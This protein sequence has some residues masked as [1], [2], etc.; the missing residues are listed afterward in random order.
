[1]RSRRTGRAAAA[2]AALL[3]TL[4]GGASLAGPGG[5]YP[6]NA[7]PGKCYE[8]VYLP[9]RYEAYVEQA[10]EQPALVDGRAAADQRPAVS[11]LV[12]KQR[13]VREASFDWR[14]VACASGAPVKRTP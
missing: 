12:T 13:L 9:A 1:M 10:L 2:G 11:R 8:K 4:F 6:P 14:E 3:A 5:D 7:E